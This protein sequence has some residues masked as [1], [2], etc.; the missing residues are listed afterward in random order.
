MEN[1]KAQLNSQKKFIRPPFVYH[2]ILSEG[3]IDLAISESRVFLAALDIS[4]E[5]IPTPGHGPDHRH[6][7]T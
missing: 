2:E 3:Y 7:R 6:T 5:I 4:G 1:Q